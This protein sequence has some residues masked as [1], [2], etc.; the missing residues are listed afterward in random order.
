MARSAGFKPIGSTAVVSPIH[1]PAR[2]RPSPG[3]LS[4]RGQ[5]LSLLRPRG[6]S[7]APG[8][9]TVVGAG[10]TRTRLNAT[11]THGRL[12][13]WAKN[14]T[15]VT[16]SWTRSP[17]SPIVT[18]AVVGG[19]PK[20][21]AL[22]SMR[23]TI[24]PC[25]NALTAAP[26][27]SLMRMLRSPITVLSVMVGAPPPHSATCAGHPPGMHLANGLRVRPRRLK[28]LL[29]RRGAT[30]TTS[31]RRTKARLS[32]AAIIVAN[33]PTTQKTAHMHVEDRRGST[34]PRSDS[35]RHRCGW[36]GEPDF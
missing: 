11:R 28:R 23:V 7:R 26:G 19:T 16:R 1:H 20:T 5:H 17:F 15:N 30:A 29:T 24:L 18:A 25:T 32:R 3:M 9:A 21:I 27:R 6:P 35:G 34:S 4:V 12:G 10:W 14:A 22:Q 33:E 31:A 2:T 36:R 13:S 8:A